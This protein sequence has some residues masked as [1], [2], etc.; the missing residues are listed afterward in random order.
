MTPHLVSFPPPP[1]TSSEKQRYE[2]TKFSHHGRFPYCCEGVCCLGD[3]SGLGIVYRDHSMMTFETNQVQGLENIK[4][5][6]GSLPFR[7]LVHQITTLD[8]HPSAQSGSIIVL[9]TGQLLIDDG[10]HPQK[11]SQCFHLIPDAGTYY[12]LNDIF[13][14]IY[15]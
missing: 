3:R 11:Y 13:R 9:I 15:G 8:A 14:L 5:K 12:V 2:L 1:P 7:K 10:E 6:L 4:E